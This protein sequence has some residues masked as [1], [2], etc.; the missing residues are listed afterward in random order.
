M[1]FR[2]CIACRVKKEKRQ[3]LRLALSADIIVIDEKQYQPG[4][5]AYVCRNE[6]CLEEAL[7]KERLARAFKKFV[8]VNAGALEWRQ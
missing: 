6:F 4:R 1:G 8:K 3:L 2:T 7:K 5:G